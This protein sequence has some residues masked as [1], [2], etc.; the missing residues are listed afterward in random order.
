VVK[1]KVKVERWSA[2]SDREQSVGSRSVNNLARQSCVSRVLRSGSG[3][4]T[5]PSAVLRK[6]LEQKIRGG[7]GNGRRGG[8]S[9]C[10][11]GGGGGGGQEDDDDDVGK[12]W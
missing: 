7:L 4:K 1:V 8:G 2:T 6:L 12:R 10:C 3:A 5:S 11:R 9:G